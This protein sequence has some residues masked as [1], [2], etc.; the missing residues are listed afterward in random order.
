[1]DIFTKLIIYAERRHT[2]CVTYM[3]VKASAPKVK[4]HLLQ[5]RNIIEI[6]VLSLRQHH[7]RQPEKC[8]Q[9]IEIECCFFPF[10]SSELAQCCQFRFQAKVFIEDLNF[11]L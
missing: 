5:P 8:S 10:L 1:M 7:I 11:V 6:S 3:T 4:M 2:R 9:W